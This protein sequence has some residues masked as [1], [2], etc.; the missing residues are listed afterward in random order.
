MAELAEQTF[1]VRINRKIV[2]RTMDAHTFTLKKLHREVNRNSDIYKQK[3]CDYVVKFNAALANNK[4]IFY[5]DAKLCY[6]R[7]RG[8]SKRGQRAVQMSVA[9][10]GK[11]IHVI[12]VIASTGVA[13]H[14]SQLGLF[15]SELSS[16]NSD[17]NKHN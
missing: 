17:M 4:K 5:L 12:E 11:N 10:K 3:R 1:S 7:G 14:E 8:R 9:S 16:D 15:M 13:Y 2:R 6:K